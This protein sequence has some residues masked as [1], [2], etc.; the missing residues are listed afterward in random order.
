MVLLV[1][2][3]GLTSSDAVVVPCLVFMPQAYGCK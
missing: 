2:S 3:H 1:S